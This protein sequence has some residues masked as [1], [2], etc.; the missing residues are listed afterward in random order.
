[1]V[2]DAWSTQLQHEVGLTIFNGALCWNGRGTF[3]RHVICV[4]TKQLQTR[5]LLA[6]EEAMQAQFKQ[7][8][9]VGDARVSRLQVKETTKKLPLVPARK[10]DGNSNHGDTLTTD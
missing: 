5:Q 7:P 10:Q 4:K 9:T 2:G 1:M 8:E 3:E 6:N